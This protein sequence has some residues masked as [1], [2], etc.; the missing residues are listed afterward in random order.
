MSVGLGKP[1]CLANCARV[2]RCEYHEINCAGCVPVVIHKFGALSTPPTEIF[3]QVVGGCCVWLL[4]VEV[5]GLRPTRMSSA[6][7]PPATESYPCRRWCVWTDSPATMASRRLRPVLHSSVTNVNA[8]LRR[9][10]ERQYPLAAGDQYCSL[11]KPY[12]PTGNS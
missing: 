3:G 9:S 4:C 5:A 10:V 1:G 12:S 6:T 8:A 11:A 2:L 7:P